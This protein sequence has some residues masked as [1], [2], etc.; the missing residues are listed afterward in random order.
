MSPAHPTTP[1]DGIV[2]LCVFCAIHCPWPQ[3]FPTIPKSGI[4]GLYTESN[5]SKRI[6]LMVD[7]ISQ[8]PVPVISIPETKHSKEGLLM[9]F[10]SR[11][12]T[13]FVFVSSSCY[14]LPSLWHAYMPTYLCHLL[15]FCL[16]P[17][18]SSHIPCVGAE[19]PWS[20][21]HQKHIH[22][23][24]PKQG[25]GEK[26]EILW[27]KEW[28]MRID[29]PN[30]TCLTSVH[31]IPEFLQGLSPRPELLCSLFPSVSSTHFLCSVRYLTHSFPRATLG[32]VLIPS[33]L[34]CVFL[35]VSFIVFS[36]YLVALSPVFDPY[37]IPPLLCSLFSVQL[38]CFLLI[39]SPCSVSLSHS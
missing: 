13:F 6:R 25:I 22:E 14:G 9:N 17:Q 34:S 4:P 26:S 7:V 1:S 12:S 32:S 24:L 33:C 38:S 18:C 10:L 30:P 19:T 3:K 29:I 39:F 16:V 31:E 20:S 27:T 5:R 36:L 37:T 2:H 35:P 15:W 23:H 28:G 21:P 8:E 11:Y